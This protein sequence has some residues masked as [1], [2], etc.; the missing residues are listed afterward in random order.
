MKSNFMNYLKKI[1]FD[2]ILYMYLLLVMRLSF[3]ISSFADTSNF[4]LLNTND[5][6]STFEVPFE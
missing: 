6:I 2:L 5:I 1:Q 4:T 3:E